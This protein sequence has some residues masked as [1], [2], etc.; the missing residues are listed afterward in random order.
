VVRLSHVQPQRGGE[1]GAAQDDAS[2]LAADAKPA[3]PFKDARMKPSDL[4]GVGT[5]Q[6]PADAQNGQ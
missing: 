4:I 1:E 6:S 5:Y 2:A 3:A